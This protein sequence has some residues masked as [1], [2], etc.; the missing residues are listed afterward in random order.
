MSVLG[1]R[2]IKMTKEKGINKAH[3]LRRKHISE[4]VCALYTVVEYVK[5][6]RLGF[7]LE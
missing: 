6:V 2:V 4:M 1:R 5:R 7:G 3:K